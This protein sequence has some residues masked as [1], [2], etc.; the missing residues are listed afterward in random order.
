[1]TTTYAHS[2]PDRPR[3][4]WH[5]LEDHLQKV[6]RLARERAAVFNAS[7]WGEYAGWLHDLGKATRAFQNYLLQSAEGEGVRGSVPHSVHGARLAVDRDKALGRL[8]AYVIAGHHGGLP[9]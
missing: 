1:M 4:D 6:A 3:E 2:R 5:L 9:D 7:Q 8:L